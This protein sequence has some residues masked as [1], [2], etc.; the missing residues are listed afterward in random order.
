MDQ[1]SDVSTHFHC[2]GAVEMDTGNPQGKATDQ[3]AG[4][5]QALQKGILQKRYNRDLLRWFTRVHPFPNHY[6][7]YCYI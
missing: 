6:R 3:L 4:K 5:Y 2:T 1:M 7:K